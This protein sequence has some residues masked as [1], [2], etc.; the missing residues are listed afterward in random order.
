MSLFFNS[1]WREK[2]RERDDHRFRGTISSIIVS[3]MHFASL[4]KPQTL[5]SLLRSLIPMRSAN[6]SLKHSRIMATSDEDSSPK[7]MRAKWNVHHCLV[8]SNRFYN[9]SRIET[10][11]RPSD[12]NG[13]YYISAMWQFHVCLCNADTKNMD[14]KIY[15][16]DGKLCEDTIF[17]SL[18]Q[19]AT[20]RVSLSKLIRLWLLFSAFLSCKGKILQYNLNKTSLS[21]HLL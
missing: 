11:L 16:L 4:A 19:V 3:R 15:K 14:R 5:I 12:I 21:R 6:C 10:E 18:H 8:K 9:E 17:S 7:Y 13:N 20:N 1:S 2:E